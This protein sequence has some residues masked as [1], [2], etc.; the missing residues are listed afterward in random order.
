MLGKELLQWLALNKDFAIN[1]TDVGFTSW[2]CCQEF[3]KPL[4]EKMIEGWEKTGE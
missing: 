3:R 1:S 2:Y 4:R